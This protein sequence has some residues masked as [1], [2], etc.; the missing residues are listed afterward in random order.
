MDGVKWRCI[1]GDG[2]GALILGATEQ[3]GG[4]WYV[5]SCFG[6]VLLGLVFRMFCFLDGQAVGSRI[7][8]LRGEGAAEVDGGGL[9]VLLWIMGVAWLV[10]AVRRG[11][12]RSFYVNDHE[13]K[14]IVLL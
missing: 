3:C 13:D 8:G 6:L 2:R 14:S 10:G 9:C 5:S 11:H 7:G 1:L 12:M 4:R